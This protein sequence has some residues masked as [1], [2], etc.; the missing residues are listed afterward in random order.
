[1]PFR[2]PMV[3]VWLAANVAIYLIRYRKALSPPFR[4]SPTTQ[5]RT[6]TPAWIVLLSD[7]SNEEQSSSNDFWIK[8][9]W[10]ESHKIVI[11]RGKCEFMWHDVDDCNK[12]DGWNVF[13]YR[14]RL[15]W[16]A[17]QFRVRQREF[18]QQ[19]LITKGAHKFI[20][21]RAAGGHWLKV[22]PHSLSYIL[23]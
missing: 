3:V 12:V 22:K 6:I 9:S 4:S 11:K 7:L 20:L 13:L 1:M 14:S 2:M 16:I 19:S 21:C 15:W 23:S 5:T 17:K 8:L 10:G 18:Q